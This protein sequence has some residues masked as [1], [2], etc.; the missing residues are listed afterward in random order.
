VFLPPIPCRATPR[1]GSGDCRTDAMQSIRSPDGCHPIAGRMPC[2]PS[3]RRTDA[4]RSQDGCHS[5]AG[6]MP[7]DCRTD[8]MLQDPAPGCHPIAG[9][10]PCNPSREAVALAAAAVS[11]SS[12]RL[13]AL[14]GSGSSCGNSSSRL[15]S[16]VEGPT[17]ATSPLLRQRLQT[18]Y[19]GC[20]GSHAL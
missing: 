13:G 20:D 14:C 2:N 7:F 9:R 6:R 19:L 12:S 4:I 3:D 1:S 17:V 10:M 11:R 5:I 18:W 8:A 15:G 16:W